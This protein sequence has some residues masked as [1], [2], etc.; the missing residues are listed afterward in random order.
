MSAEVQQESH[1][2]L[3]QDIFSKT[4]NKTLELYASKVLQNEKLQTS[5]KKLNEMSEPIV[6]KYSALINGQIDRTLKKIIIHKDDFKLLQKI[7]EARE[8][9]IGLGDKV[10]TDAELQVTNYY[11]TLEKKEEE[12]KL[13]DFE[14]IESSS[15]LE[16]RPRLQMLLRKVNSIA[17]YWMKSLWTHMK[18]QRFDK[19]TM[20]V[21][22]EHVQNK[23]NLW[24]NLT[25]AK[26]L[27]ELTSEYLQ[28]Q[29]IHPSLNTLKFQWQETQ[30]SVVLTVEGL[31]QKG[32]KEILQETG[33]KAQALKDSYV[34]FSKN[35][36]LIHLNKE[37]LKNLGDNSRKALLGI[38]EKLH[39]KEMLR[40]QAVE[41]KN[42]GVEKSMEIYT[43]TLEKLKEKKEGV[44]DR[45]LLI[46]KAVNERRMEKESLRAL[47]SHEDK[48]T[49]HNSDSEKQHE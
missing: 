48:S 1:V 40:Q 24:E 39:D 11:N 42:R 35:K 49:D 8:K 15:E 45:Y 26:I 9:F 13:D 47:D 20:K 36:V 43:K 29:F 34:E 7:S 3:L 22:A 28:Q 19:E 32:I 14:P 2:P 46:V 33:V 18:S 27:L 4:K 21:I 38:V 31:K 37:N 23:L 17:K 30:K 6:S 5:L 12:I 16:L 41:M 25:N 44:K 10:L